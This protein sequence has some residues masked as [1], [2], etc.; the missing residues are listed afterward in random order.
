MNNARIVVD[1]YNL[2]LPRGTGIAT[3]T[4]NLMGVLKQLGAQLDVLAPVHFRPS[5]KW[6]ELTEVRLLEGL[7][8]AGI[9][10][11]KRWAVDASDFV[12]SLGGCRPLRV[13]PRGIASGVA[14]A[15]IPSG[16]DFHI[17]NRLIER[18]HAH[19]DVLRQ[20]L[21]VELDA[22]V[23]LFHCTYQL[24]LRVTKAVNI[25]TIHDLIPL[26]LPGTTRDDKRYTFRLLKHLAR[27]ADHIVTVSEHSRRDIIDLLGVPESRVT[28]TY[29][30]VDI[31]P[32]V[33]T[34]SADETARIIENLFGLDYNGYFLFFGAIEPKKNVLR[35]IDAYLAS[36]AVAPLV[37]VGGAAWLAD[38][39]IER[40][41]DP[42]LESM[43]ILGSEIRRRRRVRHISYLPREFL[44][45]L[46][47]GARSVVFPSLYEGFGLP[48]LEA[49][50]LGT[51]VIT[52]NT[53]SL[54][55]VAGDAAILIDP[56]DQTGLSNAI[57]TID[58]D[59]D[60]RA[61]LARRGRDQ[62]RIYGQDSYMRRL[63]ALYKRL[64]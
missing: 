11:W 46:I 31:P 48:V 13:R 15:S 57:R 23:D 60:L 24:P 55:E 33:I 50:L 32:S 5:R 7:P 8:A 43:H 52:S 30:A 26:R 34:R 45:A 6:P 61:E 64:L 62:A 22:R 54:P 21:K 10:S 2:L 9:P 47:Q 49:M 28:N 37:V 59:A 36:G 20:P 29:Q 16:V 3:Y 1:G 58:A 39:E 4:L 12:A 44:Y 18:A 51:P 38:R 19:F 25:Y 17:V 42:Q 53:S 14:R 40:L 63:A 27:H 41:Q 56:Y 35:L